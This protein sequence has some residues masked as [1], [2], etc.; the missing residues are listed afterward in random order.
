[1]VDDDNDINLT[2]KKI[3]EEKGYYIHE[4]S[5]PLDALQKF[6]KG[7]YSLIIL[8]IKMPKMNGFEFY[9]EIIK[10]DNNIKVCFL[11]AGETDYDRYNDILHRNLC[12]RKPI[13]NEVLLK[14]IKDII[15]T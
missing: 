7:I 15:Q 2:L 14:T 4:F 10:I 6:R 1:M 5:N 3:L 13:E 11:T 12:L 9:N 8:D